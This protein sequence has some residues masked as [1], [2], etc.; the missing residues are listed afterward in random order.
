VRKVPANRICRKKKPGPPW[1]VEM[2]SLSGSMLGKKM[3]KRCNHNPGKFK[4]LIPLQ[5][6]YLVWLESAL[7]PAVRGP[8]GVFHTFPKKESQEQ[9]R[10]FARRKHANF[11]FTSESVTEG[12]P[13][14]IADQ[15]SDAWYSRS[16]AARNPKGPGFAC[17]TLVNDPALCRTLRLKSQHGPSRF[18]MI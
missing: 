1:R 4:A 18:T 3:A 6:G 15:I 8:E 5:A 9:R 16:H 12:H 13:E 2:P 17:E 10:L 7:P 11:L 14:K